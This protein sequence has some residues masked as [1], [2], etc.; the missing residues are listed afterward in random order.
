MWVKKRDNARFVV[1]NFGF[2]KKRVT[3]AIEKQQ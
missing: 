1:K 3:F 2:G